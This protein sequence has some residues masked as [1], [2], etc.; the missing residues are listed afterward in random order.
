MIPPSVFAVARI[1]VT[2][3]GDELLVYET[4]DEIDVPE[5]REVRGIATKSKCSSSLIED[6][7]YNSC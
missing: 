4:L 6:R 3:D 2:L 1:E 5:G 7:W